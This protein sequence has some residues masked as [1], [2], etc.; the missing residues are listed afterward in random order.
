MNSIIILCNFS[1]IFSTQVFCLNAEN[2]ILN[3]SKLNLNKN[4]DV[5]QYNYD[6]SEYDEN[7][8]NIAENIEENIKYFSAKN[9]RN[10]SIAQS[11][12][13]INLFVKNISVYEKFKNIFKHMSENLN[14]VEIMIKQKFN[15]FIHS[16]ELPNDCL[17]S[18]ARII[19]A[20]Q[21]SELWAF[22]CEFH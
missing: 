21:K 20:M 4:I 9:S 14:P 13:L 18:F 10:T 1:L 22:E 12:D 11:L 7:D 15:E 8:A 19:N 2:E 6:Y 17:T 3:N 5:D 16:L